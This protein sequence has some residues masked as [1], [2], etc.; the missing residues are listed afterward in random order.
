MPRPTNQ[1]ELLERAEEMYAKL[2]AEIDGLSTNDIVTDQI[3]GEWSIKDIIA[4]LYAWQQMTVSWYQAGNAGENPVTPSE[5]YTWR[6]IPALNQ[7]IYETYKNIDWDVILSDF[8]ASHQD[9]LS[10]IKTIDNDE[11]FTPKIYKW[12]RTTTVGAYFISATSSHYDWARKEIR[13]G[14][15]AKQTE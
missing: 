10:L 3:V 15:K 4:H 12:T 11:L 6:E 13:R 2:M 1:S 8:Q 14:L 5:D 9:T 7:H